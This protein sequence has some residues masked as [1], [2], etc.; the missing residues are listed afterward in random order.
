M[1]QLKDLVIKYKPDIIWSDGKLIQ[2]K[3]DFYTLENLE[4]N[5]LKIIK[6]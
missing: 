6:I 4:T 3:I 5:I 2:K 1:P